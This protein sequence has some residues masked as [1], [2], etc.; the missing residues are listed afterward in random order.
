MYSISWTRYTDNF[1]GNTP[2]PRAEIDT[3]IH[4]TNIY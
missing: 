4:P 3:F 1:V 2:R